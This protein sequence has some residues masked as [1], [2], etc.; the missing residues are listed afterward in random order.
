MREKDR[1]DKPPDVRANHASLGIVRENRRNQ[2]RSL[3]SVDDMVDAVCRL[4][5]KLGEL[6][7]TLA[8][9]MSDNGFMWGE[10]GLT[11]KIRPYASSAQVPFFVRWPGSVAAGG[12]EH[13]L[14]ANIDIA[15]TVLDAAG[16]KPDHVFDGRSLLSGGRDRVLLEQ[17]KR[18][19]RTVP[20]WAATRSTGY[21]YVE[22]YAPDRLV[23]VYREYYDLV[24]DPWELRNLLGDTDPTNDPP[25]AAELS[26]QL[27]EDVVCA[28][29]AGPSACP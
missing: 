21:L 2:L 5:D 14:V 6:D 28:G 8:I 11:Q 16:V 7:D 29:A 19:D 24:A 20:D 9:F 22:Y 18:P 1:S 10:H 3:M 15:P 23:P 27:H 4:L 25:D 13:R 12:V 26:L 17:W